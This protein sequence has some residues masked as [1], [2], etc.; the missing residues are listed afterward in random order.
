MS[1]MALNLTTH[2]ILKGVAWAAESH[3]KTVSCSPRQDSSLR[4]SQVSSDVM[5]VSSQ[6]LLRRWADARALLSL[7]SHA[8]PQTRSPRQPAIV[9]TCV[10]GISADGRRCCNA[11]SI[12]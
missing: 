1:I 10:P 6:F 12:P 7:H 4:S 9:L 2:G 8:L 11:T 5:L 3:R